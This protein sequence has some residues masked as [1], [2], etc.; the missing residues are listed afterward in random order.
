LPGRRLGSYTGGSDGKGG[1]KVTKS[2]ILLLRYHDGTAKPN[3]GGRATSMALSQILD[4]HSAGIVADVINGVRVTTDIER[5]A[6][7][8][9]PGVRKRRI[10]AYHMPVAER[11]AELAASRATLPDIDAIMTQVEACDHLVVNGEGDFILTERRSLWRCLLMMAFAIAA[12]KP[13]HLVNVMISAD[14]LGAIDPNVVDAIRPILDA[15]ASVVVRDPESLRLSAD[16]F[17]HARARLCPD[18]LFGWAGSAGA[19]ASL[20]DTWAIEEGLPPDVRRALRKDYVLVS[21]SSFLL[22]TDDPARAE[23][24]LAEYTQGLGGIGVEPVIVATC[25]GDDWMVDAARRIGLP[26][27]PA[28]VPLST[29]IRLMAHAR[30]FVSGRYHPSILSA[31]SGTPSLFMRSN[32]HKTRSLPELL[33]MPDPV[34]HPFFSEDQPV[35][36]LVDATS[37]ALAGEATERARLRTRVAELADEARALPSLLPGLEPA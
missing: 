24:R 26:A 33:A 31:V 6:A 36:A 25:S 28:H 23:A 11:A 9:E 37:T 29:G 35:A 32:S 7:E 18:S 2:K 20:A 4:N 21:G 1:A 8:L 12:G 30:L 3:W 5:T 10:P 15:C 13:V 34:E 27:V 14:R 17:P 22:R 19:L 16:V